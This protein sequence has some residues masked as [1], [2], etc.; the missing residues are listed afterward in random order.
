VLPLRNE[1]ITTIDKTDT[2]KIVLYLECLRQ[3]WSPKVT[4]IGDHTQLFIEKFNKI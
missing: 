3:D 1:L 4:I 2:H